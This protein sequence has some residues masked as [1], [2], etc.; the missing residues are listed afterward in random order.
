MTLHPLIP[1]W[2]WAVVF[3]PLLG[4]AVWQ[5]VAALRGSSRGS[6]GRQGPAAGPRGAWARGARGA[7]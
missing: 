1:L 3:V 2:A 4:L 6:V 7:N 5:L